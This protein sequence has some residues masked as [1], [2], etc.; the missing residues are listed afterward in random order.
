VIVTGTRQ[1]GV[2]A[3]DSAAPIQVVGREA[4]K[5][6]GQ[7]DLISAL[8]QILPS[9]NAQAFGNDTS[10]LTLAAALRGLSPNDTLVLVNGKR[11]HTTSN[12]AVDSGS[13]YTG[14]AAADLSFIPAAAIDHVEVLQDGAAAQ[15]GSDAIAG[16]VNI[17]LKTSDHDGAI[18]LTGGEYYEGDGATGSW[19]VNKGLS[20]GGRGF[21]NLTA[22]ETYHDFSRQGTCDARIFTQSCQVLPNLSSDPIA[23]AIDE[24]GI[25]HAT[26]FPRL[27]GEF[28]D[29]QYNTYKLFYNSGYD[30]GDRLQF[31]SFGS[32]GHRNASAYQ[33]Y[34]VPGKVIVEGDSVASSVVPFPDGFDPRDAIKED[35][36]SI[37]GGL[38]GQ[39]ATWNVDL[40]TTYG[41]DRDRVFTLDSGNLDYLKSFGFTPINFYDG[42]FETSEWTNNL[43]IS[44][45]FTVGLA[46]PLNFAFG[47]EARR[48][49]F[50]IVAGDVASSYGAGAQ[51]LPGFTASDQG[52][53]SRTNYS[54]Y[55]DLAADPITGLHVDAA[56]RYE[57]YSDFGDTEVGKLTARYDFN[58]K[59]AVRGT[60]STGFRAPTLAEEYYSATAV[61]PSFA[62]VQLPANSPAAALAGFASLKPEKSTN[63]S[64]GFIA[65]PVERM[66]IAFDA[67]R[68]DIRDRIV[69]SGFLQGSVC[70]APTNGPCA[71]NALTVISPGVNAAIAAHGNVLDSGLSYT[72]I[73]IFSNAANTRTRG[74]EATADYASDF[75]DL[76]HVDWSVGFNYNETAVTKRTPLPPAVTN[77]AAAQTEILTPNALSA[78]TT[79]TPREKTILGAL[80]VRRKWTVN[81]RETIY[82]PS[83]EIVST[84]GT[85]N[86]YPGNPATELRIPVTAV[87]DLDI[88]YKLTRSVKLDIGAD[89]L[90]DHRPPTV[91]TLANGKLADGLHVF[92]EPDQFSPFG[93]DGGYYY[94]KVTLDF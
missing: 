68:I 8:R 78:L 15:Y 90:F 14:S 91:P 29:P 74:V 94:G 31:Y 13:P 70:S 16:V 66:Q 40:A 64:V 65:H 83:S 35:D 37:I 4:L 5:T 34:R 10:Q 53:H 63:Y 2:K 81:L 77:L 80:Y 23:N 57:H 20:L 9:F 6:V 32:Y 54:A 30:L 22:E 85:G 3:A 79:A 42:A 88:G 47:G 49:T 21:L 61:S 28:G 82:G 41:D 58:S 33:N 36:Y 75:G 44:R 55:V 24:A 69:N 11:R 17:I 26:G 50:G 38:R 84:D 76:G 59:I 39:V 18:V 27:N 25:P 62:A 73:S 93:I 56:G 7:P 48:D 72:G 51:A 92:D 12:L 45:D 43:D 71:A 89:N 52:S 60:I 19:S 1:S 86:S 87:T 46:M 67:Y